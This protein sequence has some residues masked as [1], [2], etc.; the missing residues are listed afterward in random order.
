MHFGI[1][2]YPDGI[3]GEGAKEI[4]AKLS[5]LS[6]CEYVHLPVNAFQKP[7]PYVLSSGEEGAV[8]FTPSPKFYEGSKIKPTR[9][10]QFGSLDV[11]TKCV[12]KLGRRGFR[13]MPWLIASSIRLHSR[14]SQNTPS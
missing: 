8:C 5:S 11:L 13:F 1:R 6:H 7:T 4:I 10:K 2:C 14:E 9:A 3:A 12:R